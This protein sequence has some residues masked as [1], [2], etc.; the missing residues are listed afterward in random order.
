MPNNIT[1]FDAIVNDRVLPDRILPTPTIERDEFTRTAFDPVFGLDNESVR[2][3]LDRDISLLPFDHTHDEFLTFADINHSHV[4]LAQANHTHVE[5]NNFADINHSHVDFATVVHTHDEFSN[6]AQ[7]N[8]THD[9]FNNFAQSTHS[10]DEFNNFAQSVH[11]HVEFDNF[12]LL[13][14]IHDEFATFAPVVHTHA[15]FN[16]F[17]QRNHSHDEFVDF[18]LSDHTHDEF[19]TFTAA[20]ALAESALQEL[21]EITLNTLEDVAGVPEIGQALVFNGES[22]SPNDVATQSTPPSDLNDVDETYFYFGWEDLNNTGW[23]VRRQR[24]DNSQLEKYDTGYADLD[25]AWPQ[26]FT[27]TYETL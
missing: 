13:G 7:S 25:A 17:A 1:A 2:L 21:P 20:A 15:E 22:W 27:E 9:E 24:R 4:D 3:I 11:S 19:E 5:F 18:S 12:S 8:H 23:Q 26:R 14:H 16:N 6:F 10:H